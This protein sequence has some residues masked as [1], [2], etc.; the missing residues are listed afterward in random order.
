M[1]KT[2]EE[3]QG[4]SAA[5]TSLRRSIVPCP[6]APERGSPSKPREP[7][8]RVVRPTPCLVSGRTGRTVAYRVRP[9]E[10]WTPMYGLFTGL[11]PL[12]WLL[13]GPT[14]LLAL[15]AQQKV[16][17]A[18]GRFARVPVRSQLSGAEAALTLLARAGIRDVRVE[19]TR[20]WLSDHYDP[21]SRTLRLSPEVYGGRTVA[22]V[23]IAA[24]EAGHAVQ[25]A[26]GYAPLHLR[27][28]L[29]PVVQFGSWLAW[30]MIFGGMLLGSLGLVQLGIIAF[31]LLVAF[32]VVTLPVEFDASARAKQALAAAGVVSGRELDGVDEVLDAAAMTYVAAAVTAAAQLL[33]FV[34]RSGLLGGRDE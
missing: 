8:I 10:V 16:S 17:S 4:P 29:V 15:W 31:G 28:A 19:P 9:E 32:Q 5:A 27:T 20:G 3:E 12:Y 26:R 21:S 14:M 1:T 7:R 2:R 34:I 11:D 22:S 30:P 33:Y 6:P 13:I 23:G 18:Y 25:H 24:H